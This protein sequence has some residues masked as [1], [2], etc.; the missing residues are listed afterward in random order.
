MSLTDVLREE[1]EDLLAELRRQGFWHHEK[2]RHDATT[3]DINC[4]YC[5]VF[6]DA[7]ARRVSGAQAIWAYDP[8]IHPP[9]S[10][11]GG[12]DPDHCVVE[13]QGRFYDAECHEGVD[14]VRDLPIYKNVGKSRAQVLR[15]RRA[16]RGIRR[17]CAVSAQET[18]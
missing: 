10:E 15:E 14:H 16:M 9:V 3:W 12:W 13:Y 5:E 4:G 1:T 7:V 2:R 11:D 6:A 18:V 8:E 17:R